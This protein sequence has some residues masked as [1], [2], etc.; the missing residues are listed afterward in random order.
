VRSFFVFLFGFFSFFFF[1]PC[2]PLELIVRQFFSLF[3]VSVFSV[4]LDPAV[5]SLSP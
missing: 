2:V 1:L 4:P 3:T 5:F